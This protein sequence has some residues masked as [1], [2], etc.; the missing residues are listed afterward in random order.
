M[1][2][3]AMS[4]S[5]QFAAVKR[6]AV[7]SRS[8]RTR[9]PA[10]NGLTFAP[11]GTIQ[12]DLP[13]NLA[14][15]YIDFSQCYLKFKVVNDATAAFNLDRAA[16][17]GFIRRLQ[18]QTAGAQISDCD[19]FGALAAAMIDQDTSLEWRGSHGKT[20][21]GTETS[22]RGEYVAVNTSRT[23]CLPIILCP[24]S[25][26]TPHRM[27]PCFSLSALTL[28]WTLADIAEAVY[29]AG[30]PV[31]SFTDVEMVCMLTEL[32]PGAQAMVDSAT[33]GRY[34]ILATSWAYS[35]ST[36]A[37][38]VTSSTS[39]L[40]FSFS[41][42]ERVVFALRPQASQ[43][44]GAYSLGNRGTENLSEYNLLINSQQYPAQPI[45]REDKGAEALG[46]LLISD[47]SLLDWRSGSAFTNGFKGAGIGNGGVGVGFSMFANVQPRAALEPAYPFND[48]NPA[49][50][51]AGDSVN[52]DQAATASNI[53][54]YLA[55]IELESAISNGKSSH[56]YSGVS[57]LA[58]TVQLVTKHAAPGVVGDCS[59]DCWANYTILMSLN[60]RGTG[61]FSV[62]V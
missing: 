38:N 53:G 48:A 18:I 4:E 44:Q 60:M 35:G 28:R 62:S 33:G 1:S 50:T 58:S 42:L 31:V 39:N 15:T 17:Y 30:N 8:Y 10:S 34:D 45:R 47:H 11:G 55:S 59:L 14:G 46:E 40:G 61:V 56:I 3:E 9:L 51:T 49:G 19:R 2:S 32:S 6:R 41:S 20:L 43:I 13:A 29:S 54:T 5:L 52:L 36:L 37:A 21:I 24:L 27:F 12:F 26:S 23:Y 7:A 25:N 22:L 57:T 16:A